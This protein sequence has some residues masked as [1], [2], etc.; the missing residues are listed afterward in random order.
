VKK[1]GFE[2]TALN[3]EQHLVSFNYLKLHP[4]PSTH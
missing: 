1:A 3:S 2:P 4:V